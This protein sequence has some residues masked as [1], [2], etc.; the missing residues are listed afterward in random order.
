M[1]EIFREIGMIARCC[2]TMSD[3]EFKQLDLAKGQYIYLVRIY[4][5]PGIIQEKIANMINVDRTTVAKAIKKLVD[6]GM[7]E[8]RKE[9]GNRKEFR[10]YC[11]EKG[12]ELY[13]TL[14]R[15]EEHTVEVATMGLSSEEKEL[16]LDLLHRMRKNIEK[17]WEI[18]KKE[19]TR[20]Y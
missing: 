15:E 9:V 20:R 6:N 19:N 8:K 11:T 18:L 3:I 16:A 5:N 10:L 4:E 7:V 1:K 13:P 14:K 12:R 2:N 17:E